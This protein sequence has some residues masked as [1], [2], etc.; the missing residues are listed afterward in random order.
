MTAAAVGFA[1]AGKALTVLSVGLKD[2]Q[3]L[4]WTQD[5][6]LQLT[7][8]LSGITTAFAAA[9]GEKPS[10]AGSL[11][12]AVFGGAYSPNATA[13]GIDSVMGAGK[14]LNSIATGLKAFSSLGEA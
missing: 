3:K 12:G 8:V 1:A 2:Y 6:S 4:E 5:D 14:A 13:R 7:T 9:G 11:F 10:V